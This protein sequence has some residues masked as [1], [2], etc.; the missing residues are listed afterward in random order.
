MQCS[1]ILPG[2]CFKVRLN[3]VTLQFKLVTLQFKLAT[4]QLERSMLLFKLVPQLSI[5][6]FKFGLKYFCRCDLI[7]ML[8]LNRI[9]PKREP[10]DL[11]T[12]CVVFSG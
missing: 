11:L 6:Q 7:F 8:F 2:E 4:L 10:L 3:L 1:I 12:E 5:F 9:Y